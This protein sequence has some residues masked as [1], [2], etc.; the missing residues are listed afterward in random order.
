MTL[1]LEEREEGVLLSLKVAPKAKKNAMTGLHDG[2]LKIS[3]TAPPEKGKANQAVINLLAKSLH[4][5]KN[6][7]QL[8]SGET[9]QQKKILV[10]GVSLPELSEMIHLK[11]MN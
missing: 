8:V 6:Y 4:L 7:L 9:S 11:L 3:V 10:H 2:Q 5:K 1:R